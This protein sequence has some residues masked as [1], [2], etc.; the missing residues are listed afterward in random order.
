MKMRPWDVVVLGGA[1][2]DY[3]I[4]GRTV[5]APGQTVE[6]LEFQTA[7]GGKGANQ[8]VA[9]ARLGARVAFIGRVGADDRGGHLIQQ[10]ER[11]G[12]D[13]RFVTRD[14]RHATGAALIMV[15]ADGEKSILTA[16]G[17]NGHLSLASVG[18][19]ARAITNARILL[20]QFEAPKPVLLWAA[21]LAQR[22]GVRIIL[23]PAPPTYSPGEEL[24][25][26]VYLV[27]PNRHEA[28][29]LTGIDPRDRASARRAAHRLLAQGV[30]AVC[31]ESGQRGNL[32]VWAGGEQWIPRV[33]VRRVDATGAGDAYAA[34]FA[35]A[36]AEGQPLPAA[37]RFANAAAALKTTRLGAQAGLPRRSAVLALLRGES[38]RRTGR[39]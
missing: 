12:V 27:K 31:V 18:P 26:L 32:L 3:L 6:G 24:L 9:A 4:R 39:I 17:A 19:A 22:H 25:R 10:L 7:A 33:S 21:R 16:P 1:N 20:V 13:G 35:V 38:N 36:L 11:E 30:K 37:A 28:H 23:D 14:R 15:G 34:G 8:A 2:T 5:P 29:S